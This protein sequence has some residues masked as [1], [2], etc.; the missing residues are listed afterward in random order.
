MLK[1]L[2]IAAST[3]LFSSVS[4]GQEPFVPPF[5]VAM[6][7][8]NV[9][10]EG[11]IEKDSLARF[12]E[13]I[14]RYDVKGR[15]LELNSPGGSTSGARKLGYEIRDL[16]M[17]TVVRSD[18]TCASM[19][20]F[21]L[22]PAG[23]KRSIEPQANVLVHQF[24]ISVEDPK[25]C[26][27]CGADVRKAKYRGP[28]VSYLESEIGATAEYLE[29]MGIKMEL[30]RIAFQTAPWQQMYKLSEQELKETRLIN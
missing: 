2:L 1:E 25:H 18:D 12:Q 7:G 16:K 3:I 26:G 29:V 19:C 4:F 30:L 20:A 24:Y 8:D 22:L 14:K 11:V 15:T 5:H 27:V 17:N 9:R 13:F 6:V 21:A 28:D 10:M 23:I